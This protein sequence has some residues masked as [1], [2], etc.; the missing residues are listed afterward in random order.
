MDNISIEPA[1]P[2]PKKYKYYWIASDTLSKLLGR[3]FVLG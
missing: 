3:K 2:G 1:T